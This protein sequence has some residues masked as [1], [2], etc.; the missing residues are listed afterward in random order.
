M[1][2]LFKGL[3]IIMKRSYGLI[4]RLGGIV[5]DLDNGVRSKADDPK[6]R[7]QTIPK[8]MKAD[9][10]GQSGRSFLLFL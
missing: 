4:F 6:R 1:K 3:V 7:K 8:R 5:Y 9:D 10:P 2:S